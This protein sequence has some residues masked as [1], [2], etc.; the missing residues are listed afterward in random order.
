[1]TIKI[2]STTRQVLDI[3]KRRSMLPIDILAREDAQNPANPNAKRCF[4][5]L[6]IV[7]G[8]R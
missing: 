4:N 8:D 1:M 7:S 2:L 3:S 6:V 5:I